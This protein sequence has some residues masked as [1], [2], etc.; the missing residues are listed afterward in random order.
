MKQNIC[1]KTTLTYSARALFAGILIGIACIVYCNLLCINQK[2]SGA[3]LFSFALIIICQ[4]NLNLFTGKIGY[5]IDI[6]RKTDST[7]LQEI[8]LAL[9][10]N[11]LGVVLICLLYNLCNPNKLLNVIN[12]MYQD[13]IGGSWY[14]TLFNS[15][16]CGMLMFIAVNTYK[17]CNN[18]V[19][20]VV[21]IIF[22]V[23]VFI[24]CGF[25]HC[26]AN[27]GYMF[28]T[29]NNLQGTTFQIVIFNILCVVGNSVG[30]ILTHLL[31]KITNPSKESP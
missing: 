30:G 2:V 10:Y 13:K 22:C 5:A 11:F 17:K 19:I 18:K 31:Y 23:S 16:G 3:L 4:Y 26:I 14:T 20:G 7:C 9:V 15:I 25:E 29:N 28:L 27:F 21:C 24:V 8:I 12:S 1:K 6:G